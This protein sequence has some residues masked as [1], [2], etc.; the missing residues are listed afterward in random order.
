M[1]ALLLYVK[2]FYFVCLCLCCLLNKY[3]IKLKGLI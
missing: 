3:M 2:M 1:L